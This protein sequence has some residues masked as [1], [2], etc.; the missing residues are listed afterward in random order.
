[1]RILKKWK[2]LLF[3]IVCLLFTN[4]VKAEEYYYTNS[5]GVNFTK[6]Q[7]DF[8]TYLAHDGYQEVVTQK[9]LEEID[10]NH[11]ENVRVRKTSLC[12]TRDD[13]AFITTS[14]K[15][16]TMGYYCSSTHCRVMAEL[17]WLVEPN[18]KSYDLM[19]AYIDGPT[20]LTT[21]T[22]AVFTPNTISEEETIKYDTD[23]YGSVILLPDE[24]E[25]IID[26]SFLF[27]GTGTIFISYQ[28][29]MSNTTLANSQLFNIGLIGAG[30]VFDFYGAAIGVYDEMPG[31]HMDV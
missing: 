20:R 12:P 3:I 5:S 29:A 10:W 28:H 26:Q 11:L 6:E 2:L 25:I 9:M 8:Y 27:E 14:A 24:E 1:M 15:S 18:I 30:S 7:Y 19:G 31:V 17:E 4:N 16:L 13:N 22:T 21:P 23:G